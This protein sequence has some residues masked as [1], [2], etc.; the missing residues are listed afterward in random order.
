LKCLRIKTT[1]VN[2]YSSIAP[3]VP[4]KHTCKGITSGLKKSPH[5]RYAPGSIFLAALAGTA[6][7]LRR[8]A[9][10]HSATLRLVLTAGVAACFVSHGRSFLIRGYSCPLKPQK[11]IRSAHSSFKRGQPP[12]S[13]CARLRVAQANRA[14]TFFAM[15][16]FVFCPP[17]SAV[18]AV[19]RSGRSASYTP[20]TYTAKHCLTQARA[21]PPQSLHSTSSISFFRRVS[22]CPCLQKNSTAQQ[23]NAPALR[24]PRGQP[25]PS[26]RFATLR[27]IQRLP[28][29]LHSQSARALCSGQKMH[30][31]IATPH[32]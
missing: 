13:V 8:C 3:F 1:Q 30:F 29:S 31:A 25:Q 26:F 21:A 28:P 23:K 10:A 32:F 27:A 17:F 14:V 4:Q 22:P 18:F 6:A 2:R 11:G 24:V 7:T 5:L 20:S 12:L 9:P 19:F 15:F 16:R